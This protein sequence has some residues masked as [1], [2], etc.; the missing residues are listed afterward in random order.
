M[1]TEGDCSACI[2]VDQTREALV[3]VSESEG[4]EDEG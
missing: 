3:N 1:M 4:M 2:E